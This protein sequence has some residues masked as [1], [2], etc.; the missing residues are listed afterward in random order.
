MTATPDRF[1]TVYKVLTADEMAALE[2]DGRFDGSDA[3]RRDG[4][5]HLSAAD[6]LDGTVAKHFAGRDDLHLVAVDIDAHG[7][8]LRWEPSR[9]GEAFPHLYGPLNRDAVV[10]VAIVEDT[11]A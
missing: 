11:A 8:N 1:T 3:D 2:R 6:Q 7:G 9:G 5:V 4:F 10:S